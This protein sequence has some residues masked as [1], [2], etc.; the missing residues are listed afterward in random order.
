MSTEAADLGVLA[1]CCYGSIVPQI[2]IKTSL[3]KQ[4]SACCATG[5]GPRAPHWRSHE[6]ESG[7]CRRL[8]LL[9]TTGCPA[10]LDSKP[11]LFRTLGRLWLPTLDK[12]GLPGLPGDQR[13]SLPIEDEKQAHR[14][15]AL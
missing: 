15:K 11:V 8:P 13:I 4:G 7:V 14:H 10:R 9:E 6:K 3:R 1:S 5:T 12:Y 2:I